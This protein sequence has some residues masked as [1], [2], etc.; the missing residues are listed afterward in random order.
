MEILNYDAEIRKPAEIKSEF[1][2]PRTEASKLR[3]AEDLIA[4]WQ[5]GKFDFSD[6]TDRYR[7]RVKDAIAAKKKGV[8]ITPPEE[9][10]EPEVINLM[11][12]LQRSV[13]KVGSRK[14]GRRPNKRTS[15]RR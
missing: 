1:T 10:E 6:S 9:D 2:R 7:E 4:K 15:T 12:A 8:D 13:D 11:E 14:D 3:L 5:N